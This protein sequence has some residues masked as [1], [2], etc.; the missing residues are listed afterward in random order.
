MTTYTK[1]AADGSDLP[2]DATGHLAVRVE[3]PLLEKPLIFTAYRSAKEV[4]QRQAIKTAEAMDA[5]GWSWR[6]PTVDE[7]LFLPDRLKFPA[8]DKNY[9]PDFDGY[10]WDWTS[11]VDADYPSGFAWVVLLHG[12]DSLRN[13]LSDLCFVRGVRAGQY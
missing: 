13:L 11:T 12:G 7:L 6:A 3:H 1:L 2:A 10:E 4:T 5:Y 8:L 9:F